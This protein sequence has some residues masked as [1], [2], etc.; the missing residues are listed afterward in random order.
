[1]GAMRHTEGTASDSACP[2]GFIIW[3]GAHDEHP[4]D[5]CHREE[6][7]AM[8]REVEEND[9]TG[10]QLHCRE[11]SVEL[12]SRRGV[13]GNQGA[14]TLLSIQKWVTAYNPH[15]IAK[16]NRPGLAWYHSARLEDLPLTHC[17]AVLPSHNQ[18]SPAPPK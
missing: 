3:S 8:C 15:F 14:G 13:Q 10:M 17:K 18:N 12:G 16:K 2:F 6:E 1:M 11:V 7:R 4:E 9:I 5:N